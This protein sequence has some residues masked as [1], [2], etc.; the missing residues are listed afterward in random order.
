MLPSE[1]FLQRTKLSGSREPSIAAE[2]QTC[3]FSEARS[4]YLDLEVATVVRQRVQTESKI[5]FRVRQRTNVG[6][7]GGKAYLHDGSIT[8]QRE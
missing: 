6:F 4:A 3:I 2:L 7:S 5:L 1:T 8:M